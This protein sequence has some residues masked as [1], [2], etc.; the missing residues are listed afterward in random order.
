MMVRGGV[1][2]LRVFCLVVALVGAVSVSASA[3]APAARY[4]ALVVDADTGRVLHARNADTLR[5]PASLTKIMTLYLVFDAL[6]RGRLRLDQPIVFSARAA[7][8]PPSKVGLRPGETITVEDA[9]LVLVTKSANDVA[10]A[11][12]EEL[13]GSEANFALMMTAKART[14]GMSRTTFRNASGL[15]HNAQLSTA[16]DMAVLAR[17][18]LRDFPRY[19]PYFSV[20]SHEHAG[21]LYRNHNRLLASYDGLDGIKTG[22]IHASGFN[23]VASARRNGRRLIGV[24]F[25]GDNAEQ[26]NRIMARLLDA[27]F[28]QASTTTTVAAP[29]VPRP[30]L[31]VAAG[32][33]A[34][35]A[36]GM[37]AIQVGAFR[38]PQPARRIAR[39]ALDTAPEYLSRGTVTVVRQANANSKPYYL[40]RIHG[41]GGDDAQKACRKLKGKG[42]D[43]L[44]VRL[45]GA[46]AV[47]SPA[48]PASRPDLDWGVQVGAY[49]E[50]ATASRIAREAVGLVPDLLELGEVAVSPLTDGGRQPLYR[51]RILGIG[52]DHAHEACRQLAAKELPCM[53]LRDG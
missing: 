18:L 32:G 21:V 37:W 28:G 7:A 3:S 46:A 1:R 6:E 14:L 34:T 51:A 45:P 16:R 38:Q 9:I 43:C 23:L 2:V 15:P 11:I 8:Q 44:R 17:A 39:V 13:G 48:R 42:I 50:S 33:S 31:E 53:V 10:T 47:T 24:V 27:G 41:I 40:A 20:A 5:Y 29:L 25:G 30:P 4:A 36:S 22:Y 26:R 52:K 49:P 12:A 35:A 19:Y